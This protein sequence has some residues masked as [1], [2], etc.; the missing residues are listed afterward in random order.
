MIYSDKMRSITS[1][2]CIIAPR[3]SIHRNRHRI[4]LGVSSHRELHIIPLA[5][6]LSIRNIFVLDVVRRAV[7]PQVLVKLINGL[8]G[9]SVLKI[10][11]DFR[12][13]AFANAVV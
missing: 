9:W 6:F 8:Q 2:S 5:S 13:A 12:E 7:G 3:M 10:C 11:K 4:A 1:T